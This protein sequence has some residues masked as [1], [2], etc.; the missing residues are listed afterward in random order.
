VRSVAVAA[1]ALALAGCAAT[2]EPPSHLRVVPELPPAL[3]RAA[4]APFAPERFETVFAGAVR[5]LHARGLEIASCDPVFGLVATAPV[6]MDAPCRGSTC[7]ARE[8]ATVKLGYRRARV[9]VTREVWDPTLREWHVPDDATSLAHM[10]REERTLL[11]E[12]LRW[13]NGDES[14]LGETCGATGCDPLPEACFASGGAA[15]G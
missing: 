10:E 12:A 4:R 6:E 1:I 14:R 7:L 2:R 13:P 8:Y 15:G 3:P 5:A 11:D 9:T